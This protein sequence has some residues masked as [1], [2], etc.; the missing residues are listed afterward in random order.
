MDC[1]FIVTADGVAHAFLFA[2]DQG[3]GEAALQYMTEVPPP[4]SEEPPLLE[5]FTDQVTISGLSVSASMVLFTAEGVEAGTAT[6]NATLVPIG[7]PE[8]FS[9]KSP[10]FRNE[11]SFQAASIEG[12]AVLTASGI[13]PGPIS[14]DLSSC[15]GGILIQNIFQ[16]LPST[17]R[18]Q[19]DQAFLN[20]EL[21]G[22]DATATVGGF[23]VLFDG[24]P[25]FGFINA[26]I[27]PNDP[28]EPAVFGGAE[29]A[30]TYAGVDAT[31][32]VTNDA[33]DP[34]GEAT[35][36]ASFAPI[37][38]E[39]GRRLTQTTLQKLVLTTMAVSGSLSVETATASYEFDLSACQASYLEVRT[40]SHDPNGPKPGGAVPANDTPDGALALEPGDEV[41]MQTD[42]AS[43]APEEP[44]VLEEPGGEVPFGRTVWFAVEGTGAPITIDPAGTNFDTVI[45]AY[46]AGE[47]GLE[48]VACVDDD[49]S[50]LLQPPQAALTFDSVAGTT[51]YIQVGGFDYGVFTESNPD[52]GL[53]KLAVS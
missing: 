3:F 19:Q 35:L 6:I 39:S 22:S 13:L 23:G 18:D 36:S 1:P 41:K 10:H 33:G 25:L 49:F 52:F 4:D 42:G 43:L 30:I 50:T 16:V 14:F 28:S 45:G 38:V 32:E 53:L 44:C 29:A 27:T 21:A 7:E 48:Q 26:S 40:V 8:P 15:S 51:Y 9:E 24:E 17:T 46:V 2:S 11:G 5:G 12:T 37:S 20:C 47:S 34:V 31:F